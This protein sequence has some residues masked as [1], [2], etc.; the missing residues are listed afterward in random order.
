MEHAVCILIGYLKGHEDEAISNNLI[1]L[2]MNDNKSVV[3]LIVT[4]LYE[5]RLK[6]HTDIK[7]FI[8]QGI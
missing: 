4:W 2:L 7:R 1:D 6:R 5:S 8:L 3:K